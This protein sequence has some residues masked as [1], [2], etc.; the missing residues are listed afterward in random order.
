[1]LR[2]FASGTSRVRPFHALRTV[3]NSRKRF[4][5]PSLLVLCT[6]LAF[7][8]S[9]PLGSPYSQNFDGMGIPSY[10]NCVNIAG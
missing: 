6:C 5:V 2:P 7:A 8:I 10:D 4:Y 1:M 3:M 9:I